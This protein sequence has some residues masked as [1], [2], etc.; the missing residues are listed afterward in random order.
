MKRALDFL[1]GL[2]ILAS[3][4]FIVIGFDLMHHDNMEFAQIDGDESKQMHRQKALCP[5][6][7]FKVPSQDR[8]LADAFNEKQLWICNDGQCIQWRE[9]VGGKRGESKFFSNFRIIGWVKFMIAEKG[10][11][12]GKEGYWFEDL[13]KCMRRFVPLVDTQTLEYELKH[14]G[15][16]IH[17]NENDE[18]A[19]LLLFVRRGCW[20]TK[21][22]WKCYVADYGVEEFKKDAGG[23]PVPFYRLTKKCKLSLFQRRK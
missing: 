17:K 8:C 22:F 2:L 6:Y 23:W 13:D 15:F 3:F 11:K 10:C 12:C 21:E 20:R 4:I 18:S 7:Q 1:I 9:Y 14:L 16:E 5:E 19:V